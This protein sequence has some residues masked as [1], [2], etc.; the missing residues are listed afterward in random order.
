MNLLVLGGTVFVGRHVV[1]SALAAGHTVT[2]F[3]RG[4]QAGPALDGVERLIGDRDG[5]VSALAGRSFDA[6]IDCS[7]YTPAQMHLAGA[8]LAGRVGHYLFVSSRSVYRRFPLDGEIG[9]G[10]PLLEDD[11]GYGALKARSEEAIASVLP[12]RVTIVRPG[13][14]GGPFDPTGRF[15][16]WPLRLQRG[17]DVLAPGRPERP[18]QFIDARDL[19]AWCVAVAA[20]APAGVY[21]VVG[22]TTTMAGLLETIH[23]VTG[24]DARLHWVGDEA[25][26]ANGVQPWTELPLWLPESDA[27]FGGLMLGADRRAVDD[28]LVKRPLA[29]TVRD[30]LDWALGPDAATPRA[31]AT[32]TAQHEQLLLMTEGAGAPVP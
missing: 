19:A 2:I 8:A 9:P 13:L 23:G 22:P 18:V 15:T 29:H 25:L 24:G 21:D 27:Q 1:A 5:D 26:L 10:S 32:M 6:V 31:V 12:G 20:G 4:R 16:Y 17:G 14:I 11:E 30:T 3:H 7:G 28:G